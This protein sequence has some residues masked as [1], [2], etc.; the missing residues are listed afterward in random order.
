MSWQQ[1]DADAGATHFPLAFSPRLQHAIRFALETHEVYQK[2]K[3]KGK[4]IPF[5]THPL[6]VGLI[7]ARAGASEDVVMAGILHDTVEDSAA[8][9]KV[10][11][12][13]LAE[14]FGERVV[15]LV[16]LVTERDKALS[17]EDRKREA[18]AH[19]ATFSRDGLLV[20]SADVI[21]NVSE[22]ADD[23]SRSGGEVFGR[24]SAPRGKILQH[25]ARAVEALLARWPESPLAL[26]LGAAAASLRGM[27]GQ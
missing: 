23:Y 10:T 7:L 6:T 17:W 1:P 9:R 5:I 26:D 11:P 24:F 21:A 19:I 8:D 25:Y 14:R 18:L 13:M 3:R 12:G 16:D 2:Q 27:R 20:K 15:Q 22:L 4:D